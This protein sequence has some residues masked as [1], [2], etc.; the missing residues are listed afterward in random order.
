[1]TN[2]SWHDV[3]EAAGVPDGE[4]VPGYAGGL[5]IALYRIG[6]EVFATQALCSHGQA[7]LCGGFVEPDGSIEC[8]LHQGRFD[9][10]SGR[11]LCPPVEQDLVVHEVR[12]QHG[13]VWVRLRG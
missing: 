4:A 10:R 5:D 11:A 12:L 3:C 7:P 9:I 2:N 8:P 1:M 13:R 6:D